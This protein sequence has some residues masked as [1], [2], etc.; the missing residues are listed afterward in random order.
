[1]SVNIDCLAYLLIHFTDEE[2]EGIKH[3]SIDY[4]LMVALSAQLAADVELI[5]EE[6]GDPWDAT[7]ILIPMLHRLEQLTVNLTNNRGFMGSRFDADDVSMLVE[8]CERARDEEL[9]K[10]KMPLMGRVSDRDMSTWV[11]IC[12][13]TGVKDV[14]V[15]RTGDDAKDE[16][17]ALDADVIAAVIALVANGS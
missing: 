2:D 13:G 7:L 4:D 11:P 16:T 6:N 1:L 10:W 8:L 5:E 17:N 14:S 12:E 9:G 15:F 3:L